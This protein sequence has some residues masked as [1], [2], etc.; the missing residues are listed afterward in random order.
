MSFKLYVDIDKCD[1]CVLVAIYAKYEK[2]LS[3]TIEVTERT[4]KNV[5]YRH[6]V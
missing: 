6:L 2:N 1:T 4:E 5:L 3:M